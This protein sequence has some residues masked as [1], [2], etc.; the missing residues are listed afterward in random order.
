LD[1][2]EIARTLHII[3]QEELKKRIKTKI[4]HNLE[5]ERA[6]VHTRSP[7]PTPIPSSQQMMVTVL[8]IIA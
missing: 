4:H 7:M 8:C 1:G 2:K 5:A 6:S 3:K